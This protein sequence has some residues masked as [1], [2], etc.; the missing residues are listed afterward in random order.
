[1]ARHGS[2]GARKDRINGVGPGRDVQG[3][4]KVGAIIWQQDMGGDQGDTQ[5]PYRVPLSGGVNDHGH[6]GEAQVRRRV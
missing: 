5:G 2:E 1:M 3:G 6:D 4:G